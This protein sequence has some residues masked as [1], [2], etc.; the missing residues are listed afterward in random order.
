MWHNEELNK[1]AIKYVRENN[2]VKGRPNMTATSFS[3]WMNGHLLVTQ[4]L[5]PG[6]LRKVSLETARKWLMELEFTVLEHKKGTYVDGH[7]RSDVVEYRQTF[8]RRL[9]SLGFL[10]KNNAPT[11]KGAQSLP[12]DLECPFDNQINK[13]VVLFH[14]ESTFQANDDQTRY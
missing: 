14:D 13:T 11:P 8:L 6:Y 4:V 5:E 1:I 12:S 3:H 10:N 2:V 9:C 7:E